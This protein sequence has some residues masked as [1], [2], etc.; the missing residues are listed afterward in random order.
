MM[1]KKNLIIAI[2]ILVSITIIIRTIMLSPLEMLYSSPKYGNFIVT[3]SMPNKYSFRA[4]LTSNYNVDS[5]RLKCVYKVRYFLRKDD[6][7]PKITFSDIGKDIPLNAHI[8]ENE[9]IKLYLD[10]TNS[11][12][13]NALRYHNAKNLAKTLLNNGELSLNPVFLK[14]NAQGF[15]EISNVCN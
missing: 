11:K 13:Y 3:S 14:D 4:T 5:W 15:A 8:A 6:I 1:N 9:P 2:L 12:G 10:L 7:Q